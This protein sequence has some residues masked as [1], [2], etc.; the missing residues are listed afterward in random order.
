MAEEQ[1]LR[2]WVKSHDGEDYCA[3]CLYE[4]DCPGGVWQIYHPYL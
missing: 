4:E 2:E 1:R 3:Y